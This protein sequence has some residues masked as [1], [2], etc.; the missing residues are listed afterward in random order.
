MIVALECDTKL[1]IFPSHS[2]EPFKVTGTLKEQAARIKEVMPWIQISYEGR[3]EGLEIVIPRG[4][5]IIFHGLMC[6]AGA[7]CSKGG[8]T[9]LFFMTAEPKYDTANVYPCFE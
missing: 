4:H 3:K 5:A 6:H 1:V 9:R 8:D 2:G 7:E